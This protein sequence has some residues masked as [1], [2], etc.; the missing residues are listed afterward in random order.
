MTKMTKM[1]LK[2]AKKFLVTQ[3]R[4]YGSDLCEIKTLA[5]ILGVSE[6]EAG[7]HLAF[8]FLEDAIEKH[9]N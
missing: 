6:Y 8:D 7:N 9:C 2:E 5:D 4:K 1:T 3:S